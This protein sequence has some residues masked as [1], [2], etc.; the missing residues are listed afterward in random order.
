MLIKISRWNTNETHPK[1]FMYM[2][3]TDLLI[4]GWPTLPPESTTHICYEQPAEVKGSVT[5]NFCPSIHSALHSFLLTTEWLNSSLHVLLQFLLSVGC[6]GWICSSPLFCSD[7]EDVQ[8]WPAETLMQCVRE[9][10]RYFCS[11]FHHHVCYHATRLQTAASLF[12]S[13]QSFLKLWS[14]FLYHPHTYIT[15]ILWLL[16]GSSLE[17]RLMWPYLKTWECLKEPN[18]IKR[19]IAVGFVF[20][21]AFGTILFK[22][23]HGVTLI[24]T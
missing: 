22:G 13:V 7:H 15:H 11:V 12:Y 20:Q 24:C 21:T 5:L 14:I 2:D 19:H 6:L 1:G 3:S 18:H 4:S 8:R 17:G 16:Q 23:C 10:I 9:S